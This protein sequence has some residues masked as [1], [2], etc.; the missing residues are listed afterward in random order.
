MPTVSYHGQIVNAVAAVLEALP[1]AP[2]VY[3]RKSVKLFD[4]DELPCIVV[5]YTSDN[6]GAQ[7]E[8][9]EEDV[10]VTYGVMVVIVSPNESKQTEGRDTV[11]LLRLN[12][13]NA[14]HKPELTG[15]TRIFDCKVNLNQ[16]FDTSKLPAGYD[17]SPQE[18][19]Y[20]HTEPREG[21]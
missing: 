6:L 14:L 1:G 15:V 21:E 18:F 16:V 9:F 7:D 12:I 17:Y 8:T 5:A 13:R 20:I 19:Y 10:L 11:P 2:K 3:A 4:N